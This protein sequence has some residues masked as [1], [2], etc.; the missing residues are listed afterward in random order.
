MIV[1]GM[2][3]TKVLADRYDSGIF[4]MKW[5]PPINPMMIIDRSHIGL[6]MMRD[7][8]IEPAQFPFCY[9]SLPRGAH[10]RSGSKTLPPTHPVS[11]LTCRCLAGPAG[12][13][14][15]DTF[16]IFGHLLNL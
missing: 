10:L 14:P 16:N 9:R 6:M 3:G 5:N 15:Y 8:M 11:F 1:V 12:H 4:V 2:I 13:K 7:Q